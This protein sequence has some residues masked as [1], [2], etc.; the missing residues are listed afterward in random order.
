MENGAGNIADIIHKLTQIVPSAQGLAPFCLVL[1]SD[2]L[3]QQEY[4]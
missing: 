2:S 3:F 1:Y 4:A